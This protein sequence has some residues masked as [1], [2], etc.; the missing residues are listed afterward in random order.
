MAGQI[1]EQVFQ[2]LARYQKDDS[3]LPF[4]RMKG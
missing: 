1:K 2:A 4:T 3:L